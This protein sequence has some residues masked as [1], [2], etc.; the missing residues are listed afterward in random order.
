MVMFARV[1]MATS[2]IENG[3]LPCMVSCTFLH[4]ICIIY[5]EIKINAKTKTGWCEESL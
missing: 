5:Q 1:S 2:A 4:K 3:L